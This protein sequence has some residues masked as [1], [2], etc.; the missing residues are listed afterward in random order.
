MKVIGY[1]RVSDYTNMLIDSLEEQESIIRRHAE[2]LDLLYPVSEVICDHAD[3]V[4]LDREGLKKVLSML[5]SG[6]ANIL[7][8]SD[9][10]RLT[11]DLL[12]LCELEENYFNKYEIHMA[13]LGFRVR[14]ASDWLTLQMQVIMKQYQ[15]DLMLERMNKK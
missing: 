10:S 15:H 7:I 3:G 4:N 14:T 6:E 5:D 1:A 13:N 8:V 11:R 9:I 12:S 2:K